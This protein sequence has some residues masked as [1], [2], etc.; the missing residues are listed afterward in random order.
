MRTEALDPDLSPPGV[1]RLRL[2]CVAGTYSHLCL[3]AEK[4]SA[5]IELKNKLPGISRRGGTVEKTV[6]H[7]DLTCCRFHLSMEARARS[8]GSW[9]NIRTGGATLVNN[10]EPEKR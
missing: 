1:A 10:A 3:L 8:D 2:T 6:W 9:V 5:I 4:A 7:N